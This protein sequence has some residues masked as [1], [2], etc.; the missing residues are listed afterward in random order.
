LG[1]GLSLDDLHYLVNLASQHCHE[2]CEL[3]LAHPIDLADFLAEDE[4][5][6]GLAEFLVVELEH[7]LEVRGVG[8]D[9]VLVLFLGA[10]LEVSGADL[11]FLTRPF[12]LRQ[13]VA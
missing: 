5:V 8:A 12:A 1:V 9:D 3:V 7:S 6:G 2:L 4:A 11:D 10:G 13:Q